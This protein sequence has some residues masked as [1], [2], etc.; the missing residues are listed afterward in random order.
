MSLPVKII[1]AQPT[2][3]YHAFWKQSEVLW[4]P[5]KATREVFRSGGGSEEAVPR[6]ETS[7]RGGG[8]GRDPEQG[9]G[10]KAPQPHKHVQC[11][12]AG[13]RTV[14]G[15]G[16]TQCL[17]ICSGSVSPGHGGGAEPF[18]S[19]NVPMQQAEVPGSG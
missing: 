13:D 7:P 10:E 16:H 12:S 3:E 19:I 9:L 18:H 11:V 15:A 2:S 5:E 17:I 6:E 14:G 4:L 1:S 8:E